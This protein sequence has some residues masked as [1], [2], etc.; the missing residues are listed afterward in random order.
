MRVLLD[1]LIAKSNRF[2]T[3]VPLLPQLRE[4]LTSIRPG[5]LVHLST[6]I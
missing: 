6:E 3:L 2:Q 1:G 4:A 5:D